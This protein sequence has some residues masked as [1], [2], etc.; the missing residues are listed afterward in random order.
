MAG[1][2]NGS[3]FVAGEVEEF[4]AENKI[5]HLRSLPRVPQHNGSA[6]N[7][8]GDVKRLIKDGATLETACRTLN[9]YRKRQTLNWKTA[10]E[11][12][13]VNFQPCTEEKRNAFYNAAK[14]AIEAAQLGT[15]SA[16]EKRKA[17]REAIFQ[18]ME[19]FSLITRIRGH[20]R[21]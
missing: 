15:K 4:M 16:Y 21:A 20:R 14:S 9:D 19:S 17:G 1:T 10:T 8:V 7:A 5:I 12:D 13:Q 2:D 3:P 6:E 18:T 11:V